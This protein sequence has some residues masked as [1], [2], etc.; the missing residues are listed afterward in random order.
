[1]KCHV[2]AKKLFLFDN[3][4][5]QVYL[6]CPDGHAYVT[7]K[8]NDVIEYRLVWDMDDNAVERYWIQ[9]NQKETRITHSVY[10]SYNRVNLLGAN[11]T[12]L[13]LNHFMP[14][15]MKDDVILLDNIV[16]RLKKL[17]AFI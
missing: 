3:R 6:E 15:K 4:N 1:M 16:P 12:V 5:F 10:G 2:C 9:S 11:K 7:I 17:I 13:T 14:L 8:H